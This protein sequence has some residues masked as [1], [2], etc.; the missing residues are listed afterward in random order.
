MKVLLIAPPLKKEPAKPAPPPEDTIQL[1]DIVPELVE[2]PAPRTTPAHRPVEPLKPV[3][4]PTPAPPKPAEAKKP[5]AARAPM[6]DIDTDINLRLEETLKSIQDLGLDDM[7]IFSSLGLSKK[8]AAP[9]KPAE[10][11]PV[12]EKA[13]PPPVAKKETPPP[14]KKESPAAAPPKPEPPPAEDASLYDVGLLD[15]SRKIDLEIRETKD[16]HIPAAEDKDLSAALQEIDFY[17]KLGFLDNAREE[18]NK[19]SKTHANHPDIKS[20]LQSVGPGD[21]KAAPASPAAKAEEDIIPPPTIEVREIAQPASSTPVSTIKLEA[22]PMEDVTADDVNIDLF[23]MIS[24]EQPEDAGRPSSSYEVRKNIP[25]IDPPPAPAPVPAP[26]PAA[27]ADESDNLFGDI[28][29][30]SLIENAFLFSGDKSSPAVPAGQ[31]QGFFM[32]KENEEKRFTDT[33]KKI[34]AMHNIF[35]DIVEEANKVFV[36]DEVDDTDFDTHY[37]L[38]I[39]YKEMMLLDDAISE[40]QKAF[41]IVKDQISSPSFIKACHILNV[42]FFEKGLYRS[43]VKCC[44]R[45]LNSVGH[46][47]HEYQALRYDMAR[48]YEMLQEYKQALDIYAEIYAEDIHY[49][50]V[51]EK[52]DSLKKQIN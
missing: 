47:S 15:F 48:A 7:G 19:L 20:R 34:S 12:V 1:L 22:S 29:A 17:I 8:P 25:V 39:A 14:V 41:N 40:F 45:G 13:A 5:A 32:P 4:P 21:T 18:L 49:R 26:E 23:N 51:T 11:P 30:D 42:C 43:A 2:L 16:A 44:E 46:E 27:P 37:N 31:D 9:P 33:D 50:D 35:S 28:E 38:G 3:E 24:T 52:I 6:P 10:P 36:S